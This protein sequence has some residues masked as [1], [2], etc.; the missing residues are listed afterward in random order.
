MDAQQHDFNVAV[1]A[2]ERTHADWD[3]MIRSVG[4]DR[5]ERVRAVEARSA[6]IISRN[7]K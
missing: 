2:F 3:D 5:M 6:Q 1:A 7:R 4:L